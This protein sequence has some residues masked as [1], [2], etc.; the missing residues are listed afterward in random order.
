[1]SDTG[2]FEGC[3]PASQWFPELMFDASIPSTPGSSLDSDILYSESEIPALVRSRLQAPE[4]VLVR[5]AVAELPMHTFLDRLERVH[6]HK[7]AH[8]RDLEAELREVHPDGTVDSVSSSGDV[9]TSDSSGTPSPGSVRAGAN[10]AP[11]ASYYIEYMSMRRHLTALWDDVTPLSF[12][13]ELQ[14]EIR[15]L[16]FGDGRTV[17]KLHFDQYENLLAVVAGTKRVRLY[18]PYANEELYEGH[19]REAV[20]EY[21]RATETVYRRRLLKSTSMVRPN[22][23]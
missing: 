21:D 9:P 23:P 8:G 1:M 2:D 3:E 4:S 13:S 20:L 17:G 11:N 7:K 14:H 19:V 5:P 18:H 15:N 16:W 22:L 6:K 12:A 10:H